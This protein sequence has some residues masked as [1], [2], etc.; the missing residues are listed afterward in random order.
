MSLAE[1]RSRGDSLKALLSVNGIQ[2]EE[3]LGRSMGETILYFIVI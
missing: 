1:A 2:K 3:A